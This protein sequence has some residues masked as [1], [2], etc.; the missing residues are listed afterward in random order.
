MQSLHPANWNIL[1]A[2]LKILIW[3]KLLNWCFLRCKFLLFL[4]NVGPAD[5]SSDN[6]Y[7]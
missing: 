7:H 4:N 1:I 2:C 5:L 3:P 6:V